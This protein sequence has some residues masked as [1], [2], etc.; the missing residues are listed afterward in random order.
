MVKLAPPPGD[1]PTLKRKALNSMIAEYLGA[2]SYQYSLS[3]F[4]EEA[5]VSVLSRL[6]EEELVDVLRIERG[7]PLFHAMRAAKQ[8]VASSGNAQGAC[9]LLHL[10]EALADVGQVQHAETSKP[11]PTAGYGDRYHLEVCVQDG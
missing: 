9:F 5:N 10:I 6:S 4:S 1:Q 11:G 7:S 8:A 3:V 2:A